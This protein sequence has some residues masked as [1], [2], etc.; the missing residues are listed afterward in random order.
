MDQEPQAAAVDQPPVPPVAP[1]E[2]PI[3][4]APKSDQKEAKQ[5]KIAGKIL[6]HKRVAPKKAASKATATKRGGG[7][8]L[9][10]TPLRR[11]TSLQARSRVRR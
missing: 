3:H 8:G 10:R 2:R 1:V 4:P 7:G 9:K 5:V 6:A 11:K